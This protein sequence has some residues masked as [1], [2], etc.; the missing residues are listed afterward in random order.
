MTAPPGTGVSGVSGVSGL[1][2]QTG[3]TARVT[4]HDLP[5]DGIPVLTDMVGPEMELA[6]PS[7]ATALDVTQ[8]L[9]V[10]SRSGPATSPDGAAA[11][12]DDEKMD[13]LSLRIQSRVL[14]GLTGR[15]DPI[16]ERRLRESLTGL[17]EQ[18][19][20]G[21][22]AELQMTVQTIVRDAVAQAVA[23]EM[24]ELHKTKR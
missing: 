4:R 5:D 8:R 10:L 15:I 11:V 16:V 6:A 7:L 23:A 20:A 18:V 22:T 1:A 14:A 17:L 12:E 9:P 24:A 3:L 2:G 21:M 19:L 13:A